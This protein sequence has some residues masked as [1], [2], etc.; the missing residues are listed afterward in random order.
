MKIKEFF[1]FEE[2][3]AV[4]IRTEILAGVTT[5]TTMAYILIVNPAML[6]ETGMDAGRVFSAVAVSSA[7]SALLMGLYA[8]LPLAAAS[9][10]GLNAFFT[11]TVCLG[12]GYSWKFAMTAVFAESLVFLILTAAGI[13]EKIIN[14]MPKSLNSGIVAGIGLFIAFVGFQ[15][16]GIA[17]R[18]ETLIR[19]NT[20]WYRG[21]PMVALTGIVI[22]GVLLARKVRSALFLG[23]ILTAAVGIPFG[24]TKWNGSGLMSAAPYFM[25]F[26]LTAVKED[27]P[28]FLL[29]VCTFVFT[30]LF[31]EVGTLI[32]CMG[33]TGLVREDGSIVN[34][35]KA[36]FADCAGKIAGAVLGTSPLTTYVESAAGVSVGGRTGLTACTTGVLFLVSLVFSP[37][38][39][40]VPQAAVTPALVLVGAMMTSAV[41][42]VD[43]SDITEALPA[44]VCMLFMVLTFSIS[45]G[46]GFGVGTYVLLKL[47]AGRVKEIS[48]IVWTVFALF[49]VKTVIVLL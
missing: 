48:P 33:G 17:V 10:M 31:E 49:A 11:Y 13:R 23:I 34:C 28:G 5:F 41:L 47:F 15:N 24:V 25:P 12:M 44:F 19:L 14:G 7:L 30:D 27:L 6:A 4:S 29:I 16:A 46:I 21:A 38:L 43:F 3:G 42:H 18:G 9:G 35:R 36:L 2:R 32:G 20:E 39:L 40:S 1:H 45:N 22:T 8:N 37:I 26:D